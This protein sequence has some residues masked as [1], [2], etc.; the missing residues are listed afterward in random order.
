MATR[1]DHKITLFLEEAG[2][3][4]RIGPVNIGASEQFQPDFLKIAPNN[5]RGP[6]SEDQR[7]VLFG[8]T[9]R[10]AA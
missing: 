1:N 3:S 5:Y 8:Q 9:A 2:V 7:K 4:Y 6:V 10:T